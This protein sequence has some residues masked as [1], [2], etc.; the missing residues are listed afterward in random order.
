MRKHSTAFRWYKNGTLVD[1]HPFSV[2]KGT[3]PLPQE[4]Q[5]TVAFLLQEINGKIY[6]TI[7]LFA[8]STREQ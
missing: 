6:L 1:L 7:T 2:E 5:R 3:S 4:E 8:V